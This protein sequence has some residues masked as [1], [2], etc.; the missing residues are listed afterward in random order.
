MLQ[1]APTSELLPA[2]GLEDGDHLYIP[3]RPNTVA[4]FRSV[5]S[6]GSFLHS[7]NKTVCDYL[8]LAGGPTKG[9]DEDSVF[10]VR[11]NGQVFSSRQQLAGGLW[12]SRGNQIGG[13]SA[14]P[15]DTVFCTRRVQ[16]VDLHP[17]NQ[18]VDSDPVP[19][20][21]GSGGAKDGLW[22]VIGRA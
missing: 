17:G 18:G 13:I 9:A 15:G 19:V 3:A 12:F 20:G 1:V 16:Q 6:T 21:R 14:E 11:A 2:M 22:V 5:F 8:S 7:P 10:V 4:V